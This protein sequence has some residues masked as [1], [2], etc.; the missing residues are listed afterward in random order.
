MFYAWACQREF[1][2]QCGDATTNKTGKKR[3][4]NEIND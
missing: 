1:L 3:F 2:N 4:E